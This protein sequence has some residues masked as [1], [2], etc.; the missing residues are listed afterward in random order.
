MMQAKEFSFQW[1]MSRQFTFTE[2]LVRWSRDTLTRSPYLL[3][4]LT[5]L[6]NVDV[7]KARLTRLQLRRAHRLLACQS[8]FRKIILNR[9]IAESAHGLRA[10][11]G[12]ADHGVT[13]APLLVQQIARPVHH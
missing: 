12:M 8:T 13:D 5:H 9:S 4:L 2:T 7:N 6:A 3:V 11:V 10:V 1:Q